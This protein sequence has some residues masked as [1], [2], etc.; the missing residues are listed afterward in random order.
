MNDR[1][2][3]SSFTIDCECGCTKLVLDNWDDS[4]TLSSYRTLF[5]SES[6]GFLDKIQKRVK[7][8][9]YAVTGKDYRLYEIVLYPEHFEQFKKFVN[10]SKIE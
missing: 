6:E 3:E 4:I 10:D 5:Q 7:S 1:H 9:W 2:N 8:V